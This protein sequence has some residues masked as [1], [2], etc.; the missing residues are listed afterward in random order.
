METLRQFSVCCVPIKKINVV[1]NS[2]RTWIVYSL[3][4][5]NVVEIPAHKATLKTWKL[6]HWTLDQLLKHTS[7]HIKSEGT[8]YG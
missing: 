1:H 5:E 4:F 7:S 8:I 3:L 6:N 2:Q